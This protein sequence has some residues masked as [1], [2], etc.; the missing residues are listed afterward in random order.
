MNQNL[1]YAADGTPINESSNLALSI[2]IQ[3]SVANPE[4]DFP[5]TLAETK[6][7]LNGFYF[8]KQTSTAPVSNGIYFHQMTVKSAK[9]GLMLFVMEDEKQS[10]SLNDMIQTQLP[11]IDMS[12]LELYQVEGGARMEKVIFYGLAK[13]ISSAVKFNN[14]H[15]RLEATFKPGTFEIDPNRVRFQLSI[16]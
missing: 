14:K 2:A 4:L 9:P 15:F 16:E 12:S 5:Q 1:L 6:I 11:G 13:G 10:V 3:L 7:N 8:E